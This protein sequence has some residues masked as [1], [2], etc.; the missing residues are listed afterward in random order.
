MS[1]SRSTEVFSPDEIA[2]A[3][4]LPEDAVIAVVGRADALVPMGEAVRVVRA[5][6]AGQ[7]VSPGSNNAGGDPRRAATPPSLFAMFSTRADA[8]SKSVPLVVSSTVHVTILLA[9]IAIATFG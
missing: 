3:A 7:E 1:P 6:R 9:A 5:L 8:P 4:G 2:R